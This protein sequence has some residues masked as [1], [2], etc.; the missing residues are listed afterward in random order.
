MLLL[1]LLWRF[2]AMVTHVVMPD[3]T[4]SPSRVRDGVLRSGRTG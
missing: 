4:G 2:P 3:P 1:S